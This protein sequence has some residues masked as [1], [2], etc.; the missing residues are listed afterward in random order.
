MFECSI[1]DVSK[2]TI[3]DQAGPGKEQ[4]SAVD[5]QPGGKV[6]MVVEKKDQP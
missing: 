4:A 5:D 1:R 3:N 2:V 6:E